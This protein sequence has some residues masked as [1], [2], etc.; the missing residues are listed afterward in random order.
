MTRDYPIQPL[1]AVL[2]MVA[3]HGRVLLVR[4][5]KPPDRDKWGFPGGLVEVGET[6]AEAAMRELAEETG[7]RA[8]AGAVAEVLSVISRDAGN[9]VRNHY[10][11]LAV[12]MTWQAGEPVAAS[13]AAEAGWFTLEAIAHMDCHPDL[14][15]LAAALLAQ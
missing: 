1:P 12:R 3:R 9:R 13:D 6:V 11:L 5:G 14:P 4:R 7:V 2:A 10:I 8:E 15:R